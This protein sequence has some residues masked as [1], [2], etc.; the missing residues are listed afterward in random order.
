MQPRALY[1]KLVNYFVSVS[2]SPSSS[3][4][5]FASFDNFVKMETF[6]V[7]VAPPLPRVNLT[8]T[9]KD[10][11]TNPQLYFAVRTFKDFCCFA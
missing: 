11:Q 5:P 2:V 8:A 6:V 10:L 1:E 7:D 9:I 4:F 3:H